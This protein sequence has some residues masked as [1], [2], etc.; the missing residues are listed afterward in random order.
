MNIKFEFTISEL[1]LQITLSSPSMFPGYVTLGTRFRCIYSNP[2]IITNSEFCDDVNN[3]LSYI[4]SNNLGIRDI[5]SYSKALEYA[6]KGHINRYKRMIFKDLLVYIDE[7]AE[8]IH[9][10]GFAENA[11]RGRYEGKDVPQVVKEKIMESYIRDRY[12]IEL[13]KHIDTCL[14]KNVL[15]LSDSED[16]RFYKH[17]MGEAFN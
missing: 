4:E 13:R 2:Q 7:Y 15:D 3:I 1:P 16:E 5:D 14:Q 17:F 12:E 10:L 6:I 9:A 8:I 11:L